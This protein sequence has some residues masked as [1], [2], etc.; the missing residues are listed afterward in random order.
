[1]EEGTSQDVAVEKSLSFLGQQ[2]DLIPRDVYEHLVL[3]CAQDDKTDRVPV[4]KLLLTFSITSPMS[5]RI[6]CARKLIF[7]S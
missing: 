2:E 5:D 3:R 7:L 1:M 4:A 6:L